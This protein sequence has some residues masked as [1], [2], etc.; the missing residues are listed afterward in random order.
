M[1]NIKEYKSAVDEAVTGFMTNGTSKSALG[2]ILGES[3]IGDAFAKAK[4]NMQATTNA[5][6]ESIYD[7]G[8]LKSDVITDFSF[9]FAINR[10]IANRYM[11][12]KS[13]YKT[14]NDKKL[15]RT[16]FL[17]AKNQAEE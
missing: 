14:A 13:L 8:E 11:C 1:E 17:S 2:S 16:Y 10:D 6:G 12:R 15:L 3:S 9:S 4:N 7:E 5:Y